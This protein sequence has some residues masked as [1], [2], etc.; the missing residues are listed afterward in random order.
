M[1]HCG[2]GTLHYLTILFLNSSGNQGAAY[3]TSRNRQH[4]GNEETDIFLHVL[5][6]SKERSYWLHR[7]KRIGKCPEFLLAICLSLHILFAFPPK[8]R[9]RNQQHFLSLSYI[10]VTYYSQP[11]TPLFI[12]TFKRQS[13]IKHVSSYILVTYSM[14]RMEHTPYCFG[15]D[16]PS[17]PP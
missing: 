7:Y 8:H 1:P 14:P 3:K 4:Y 11:K 2:Y 15:F 13:S 10:P 5:H 9:C 12:G 6:K 17:S 16:S